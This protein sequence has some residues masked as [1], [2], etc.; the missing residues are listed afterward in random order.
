MTSAATLTIRPATEADGPALTRIY[1]EGIVDR[2]ATFETEERSDEERR[3]WLTN[4]DARHP[5]FVAE[6]D[7]AVAGW[8][9]LNVFNP[10]AAYRFVGELS[11]YVGREARGA[12]VGRAL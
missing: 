11:V 2:I 12:G 1:N 7:G 5:V 4:R 8:V 9:A 6:R 3:A 10:R